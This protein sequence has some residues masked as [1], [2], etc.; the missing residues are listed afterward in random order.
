MPSSSNTTHP[1]SETEPRHA[2]QVV[3]DP[4]NGARQPIQQPPPLQQYVGRPAPHD[5]PRVYSD[6]DPPL[7]E[8]GRALVAAFAG[9]ERVRRVPSKHRASRRRARGRTRKNRAGA[10]ERVEGEGVDAGGGTSKG[11]RN[12]ASGEGLRETG[13]SG[14]SEDL[15][16]WNLELDALQSQLPSPDGLLKAC[17]FQGP[18][19]SSKEP[20]G[21][22]Q[23]M[24]SISTSVRRTRA[25]PF[26]NA[27]RRER[28]AQRRQPQLEGEVAAYTFLINLDLSAVA[29][30]GLSN[31]FPTCS[32]PSA[33]SCSPLSLGTPPP[34]PPR[35]RSSFEGPLLMS[36]AVRLTARCALRTPSSF[37][38]EGACRGRVR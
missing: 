4:S 7:A 5:S 24:F 9:L 36:E 19:Y 21:E 25:N 29:S 2:R 30:P 15:G 13:E 26:P 28:D 22:A 32:S 23:Q 38:T 27:T 20:A 16:V 12:R 31:L 11:T 14:E 34:A 18:S 35:K 10:R 1:T 6:L 17:C 3:R 8:D 37:S 33:L